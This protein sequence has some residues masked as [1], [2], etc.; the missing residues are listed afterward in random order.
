M[1]TGSGSD[2]VALAV[3]G[4]NDLADT[5]P[6]IL[7]IP[8]HGQDGH[9][10]GTHGDAEL[11]LHQVAVLGAADTD[12]DVAQTLGAE[13]QDPAHLD[14]LGVDVQALEATLGQLLVIVIALMLHTGVEGYHGKVVGVHDVVDVAGEAQGELGHGHQQGVAAAG[15]S[16][17]DV[18]GGA[19]G[20]LTQAAAN[21]LAQFAQ[22]FDQAQRSGG[23]A[24]AKGSGG[25][26]SHVNVFAVGTGGQAV[27]DGAILDFG[28]IVSIGQDFL[29]F[30][31]E[32]SGK[33]LDRF[34]ILFGVQGNLS[35]GDLTG[36]QCHVE[37]P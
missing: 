6:Q 19:A 14:A 32:L 26:G 31:T 10:L 9:Q 30:E 23:L 29:L 33:G 35:V 28:H 7:Q 18:H 1:V 21:V 37:P 15:R 12:D 4:H 27:E 16:T 36:I 11:G 5:L 34:H 20:G 17:L 13:V 2:G 24:L 8:G 25:D 3:I 22:A